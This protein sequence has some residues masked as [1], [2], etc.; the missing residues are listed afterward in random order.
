MSPDLIDASVNNGVNGIVV[1]GVGNGNMNKA[2][3]EAAA[4]AIKR[5]S[6]VVRAT[7]VAAG[8]RWAQRGCE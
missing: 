1:A 8:H 3:V 7:H 4:R 6:V 5:G 2:S